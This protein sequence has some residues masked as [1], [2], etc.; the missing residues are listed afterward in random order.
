[1]LFIYFQ[2]S[3]KFRFVG[4]IRLPLS[5]F[6]IHP[7]PE[8]VNVRYTHIAIRHKNSPELLKTNSSGEHYFGIIS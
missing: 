6:I 1:M 5:V 7:I 4:E 2:F 3:S 8:K